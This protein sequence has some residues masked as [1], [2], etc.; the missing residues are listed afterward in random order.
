MD[1][2]LNNI[3]AIPCGKCPKTGESMYRVGS[4]KLGR[5][6]LEGLFLATEQVQPKKRAKLE[7]LKGKG[8][9]LYSHEAVRAKFTGCEYTGIDQ[10]CSLAHA[11]IL[12]G[13]KHSIVCKEL[14]IN[15]KTY[16][17]WR[18]KRGYPRQRKKKTH[19]PK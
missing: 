4:A 6:S 8:T 12:N 19:T 16:Y 9:V 13:G 7:N 3:G 17:K 10:K 15:A 1:Q 2:R 14:G 5:S 11:A 18:A